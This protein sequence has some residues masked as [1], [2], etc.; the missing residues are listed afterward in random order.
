MYVNPAAAAS[1]LATAPGP[2]FGIAI[3][4]IAARHRHS[5]TGVSNNATTTALS[6]ST[7]AAATA[8]TSSDLTVGSPFNKN[9]NPATNG[10]R[11]TTD[12]EGYDE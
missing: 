5:K 3:D 7:P 6:L 1:L 11:E 9:G 8:A 10:H 4:T 12:K 2:A